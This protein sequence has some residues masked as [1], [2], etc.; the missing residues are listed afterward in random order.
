MCSHSEKWPGTAGARCLS[1][2]QIG[3]MNPIGVVTTELWVIQEQIFS[4][5]FFLHFSFFCTFAASCRANGWTY[6]VHFW[7]RRSVLILPTLDR[8]FRC[9]QGSCG[10]A[11]PEIQPQKER[12]GR[13]RGNSNNLKKIENLARYFFF[14][15][16][17]LLCSKECAP[18]NEISPLRKPR[19]ES[20]THNHCP[21][22]QAQS[23][24]QIAFIQTF[25]RC[26]T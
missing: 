17:P 19:S 7:S 9:S 15:R 8:E 21:E 24:L 1:A 5:F 14:S 23:H 10:S 22:V 18:V 3:K 4:L 13:N 26:I 12:K 20:K 2:Q 16:A 25:I 6:S 11:K